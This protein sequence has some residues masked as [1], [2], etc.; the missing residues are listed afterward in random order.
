MKLEPKIKVAQKPP[1][2]YGHLN[3][4]SS[5]VPEIKDATLNEEIEFL[6]TVKVTTLRAPDKWEISEGYKKPNE[7]CLSGDIM[8]IKKA[9]KTPAK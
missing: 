9:D 4:E 8:K 7:V 2:T 1:K 5:T 3:I 6:I